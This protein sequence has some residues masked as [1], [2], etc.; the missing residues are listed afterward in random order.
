MNNKLYLGIEF[1]ST[2]IKAMGMSKFNIMV[3]TKLPKCPYQMRGYFGSFHDNFIEL[4]IKLGLLI[5]QGQFM[6]IPYHI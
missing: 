5:N 1:G 3:K 6:I 4:Y 2:R